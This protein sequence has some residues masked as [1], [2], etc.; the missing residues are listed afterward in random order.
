MPDEADEVIAFAKGEAELADSCLLL[1]FSGEGD[2]VG[3]YLGGFESQ[4]AVRRDAA[5][6][7]QEDI[8]G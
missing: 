5:G 1:G 3:G 7:A 6:N 4:T 8:D 2:F